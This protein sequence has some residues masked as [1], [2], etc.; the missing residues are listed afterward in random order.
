MHS[1]DNYEAAPLLPASS[2][3][4]G[5]GGVNPSPVWAKGRVG[6]KKSCPVSGAA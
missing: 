2:P 6:G 5:R 3:R 4:A 1:S